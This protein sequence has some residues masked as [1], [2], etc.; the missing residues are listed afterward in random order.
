MKECVFIWDHFDPDYIECVI[1][2]SEEIEYIVNN[3][4]YNVFR[5]CIT[6]GLVAIKWNDE[7]MYSCPLGCQT[8]DELKECTMKNLKECFEEESSNNYLYIKTDMTCGSGPEY[9]LYDEDSPKTPEEAYDNIIQF[10]KDS[11]VDGD[12]NY[13][14]AIINIEKEEVWV[15]GTG[16][17]CFNSAKECI[18]SIE[19]YN[20]EYDE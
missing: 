16:K 8:M 4:E 9:S 1:G 3:T 20:A 14:R 6:D 7:S 5:T 13:A 18:S 19:R 17:V 10:I 11:Y 15:Q 2:N 12:S